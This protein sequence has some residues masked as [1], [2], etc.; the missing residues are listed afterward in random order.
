MIENEDN[1][2][3]GGN[4]PL[5]MALGH[6]NQPTKVLVVDDRSENLK[7]MKKLLSTL[8]CEAVLA[9]SG[10]EAL[11]ILLEEKFACILLDVQM[12]EL[13][14]F[15]VASILSNDPELCET[16]ILFL[17]AKHY[18][19]S[20]I[21]KG[22]ASGS[23]DYLMKPVDPIILK[24][25][26][27]VFCKLF[28]QKRLIE[29]QAI[30]LDHLYNIA[31]KNLKEAYRDLEQFAALASHDLK[32]PMVRMRM[33]AD[34]VIDE[35]ENRVSSP[36]LEKLN[37]IMNNADSLIRVTDDILLLSSMRQSEVVLK[38]FPLC[39]VLEKTKVDY[40]VQK[41]SR[42]QFEDRRSDL[43]IYASEDL[44]GLV[45]K[46]YIDNALKYTTGNEGKVRVGTKEEGENVTIYVEDNGPGIPEEKIKDVF[47]PFKQLK[48]E[49]PG[50]G[51][52][53]VICAKAVASMQGSIDVTSEVG[54]GST[55][56]F[57]LPQ[58]APF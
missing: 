51:L 14:G 50:V 58:K 29:Q 32:S 3:A 6:D 30:K 10:N 21:Y 28:Q 12:P 2:K 56:S 7:S 35:E 53:L 41:E 42:V 31:L 20:D 5:T 17:T 13:D 55:F 16:P 48:N 49:N 38:E 47:Q 19:Q 1:N 9:E 34:L 4:D 23:V 54:V 52:G 46:N 27:T 36:S 22:Y 33:L 25:K 8:G 24:S 26:V 18:D 37:M 43:S 45:L 11:Q 39:R 44:V 15:E 57:T 40:K